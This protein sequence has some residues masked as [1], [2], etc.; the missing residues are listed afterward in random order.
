MVVNMIRKNKLLSKN[1]YFIFLNNHLS[2]KWTQVQHLFTQPIHL[3]RFI[4]F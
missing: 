3:F 2:A 4:T 1:E